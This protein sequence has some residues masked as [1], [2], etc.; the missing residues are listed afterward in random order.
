MHGSGFPSSTNHIPYFLPCITA[1]CHSSCLLTLLLCH[2]QCSPQSSLFHLSVCA[3]MWS[4]V[5]SSWYCLTPALYLTLVLFP[6]SK[7]NKPPSLGTFVSCFS[8]SEL[9]LK[10]AWI[11]YLN[12]SDITCQNP[13]SLF[14][15]LTHLSSCNAHTFKRPKEPLVRVKLPF[16]NSFFWSRP[17]DSSDL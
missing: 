16:C 13:F 17:S 6:L 2:C 1:S 12:E 3:W 7:M 11:M 4:H 9:K 8:T 5:T 10:D 14:L 15:L